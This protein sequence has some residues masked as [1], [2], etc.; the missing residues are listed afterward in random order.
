MVVVSRV[1]GLQARSLHNKD[2]SLGSPSLMG[3]LKVPGAFRKVLSWGQM[4]VAPGHS[5]AGALRQ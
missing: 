3:H 5:V 4:E 2:I 1:M